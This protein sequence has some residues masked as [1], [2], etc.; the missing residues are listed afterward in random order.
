MKYLSN[1]RYLFLYQ[2][3]SLTMETV[4]QTL[5]DLCLAAFEWLAL[6]LLKDLNT[7]FA[8]GMERALN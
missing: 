1:I 4:N 2:I 8:E 6:G 5:V 3:I 7:V